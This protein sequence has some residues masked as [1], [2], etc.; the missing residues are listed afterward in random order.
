MPLASIPN[1]AILQALSYLGASD[2]SAIYITGRVAVEDIPG[3]CASV[4]GEVFQ[5]LLKKQTTPKKKN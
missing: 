1:D 2:I 4:G 5:N 3:L